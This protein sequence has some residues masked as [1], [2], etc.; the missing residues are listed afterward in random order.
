MTTPSAP[1]PPELRGIVSDYIDATTAAADSTTDA[2]LVLDDDAHLITAHLSGDW[3]DEDRA[4]RGRAH[5][6]IM[7]LLDTATDRDLAAVRDELTAAAELLLT[8]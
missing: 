6:T 4:H 1:L 2:A 5:Q 8:R 7:T 3:D